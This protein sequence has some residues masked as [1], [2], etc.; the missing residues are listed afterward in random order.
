MMFYDLKLGLIR[1]NEK[2]RSQELTIKDLIQVGYFPR[3]RTILIMRNTSKREVIGLDLEGNF[4][5]DVHPP[6]GYVMIYFQEFADYLSIV[7]DGDKNHEDKFG[8]N[9]INFK[10]DTIDGSLK[11]ENLA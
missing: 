9:R 7:C 5:Y 10:L 11:K 6:K 2:G 4:L 3:K 8:R 1:W